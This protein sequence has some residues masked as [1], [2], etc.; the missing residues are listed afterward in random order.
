MFVEIARLIASGVVN[1]A[2]CRETDHLY[3]EFQDKE[4][5]KEKER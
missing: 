1:L 4:E 5:L 3:F 2:T